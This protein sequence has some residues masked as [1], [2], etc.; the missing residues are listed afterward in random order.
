MRERSPLPDGTPAIALGLAI[1]G[2]STYGFLVLARRAV[3]D[4]AYGGL[5]IVWSLVYILGPGL[6]QPLEQEVARATAARG[7]LGQ[8]SAPV[9]RQ[10][11]NIGAVFLAL[12]FTGVLVAWPLGL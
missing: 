3:G 11:A 12:V 4:E 7:S 8:G 6:F 5:A 1:N 9:L 10:A 2:I